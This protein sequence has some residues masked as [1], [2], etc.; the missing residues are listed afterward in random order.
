[1]AELKV[2]VRGE[3]CPVPLVE[4]RKAVRKSVPGDLIEVTGT[5]PASR[6]E[7][8]MAA[9]ALKMDVISDEIQLGVWT[10][11]IRR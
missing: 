10:I 6:K 3:T 9:A 7:I 8:P 5:N 11:R 2:D 4:F 1:M